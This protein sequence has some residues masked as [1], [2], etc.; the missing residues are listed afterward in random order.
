MNKTDENGLLNEEF[1]SD[2]KL[3]NYFADKE[4]LIDKNNKNRKM[5]KLK[6]HNLRVISLPKSI[7]TLDFDNK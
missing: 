7:G 2:D 6:N 3:K 5:F 4:K 1:I